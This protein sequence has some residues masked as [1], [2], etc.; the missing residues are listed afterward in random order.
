MEMMKQV[1]RAHTLHARVTSRQLDGSSS[2]PRAAWRRS[3]KPVL[4]AGSC[5]DYLERVICLAGFQKRADGGWV[6]RDPVLVERFLSP[7]NHPEHLDCLRTLYPFPSDD[8]RSSRAPS[9][10]EML[11]RAPHVE[12]STPKYE[13]K[14]L[15]DEHMIASAKEVALMGGGD[16]GHDEAMG[17][18]SHVAGWSEVTVS[19]DHPFVVSLRKLPAGL[20]VAEVE[21]SYESAGRILPS[22]PFIPIVH[23]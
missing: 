11:P 10:A 18:V 5:A 23:V 20:A 14:V 15:Y 7:A 19:A 1:K 13:V 17:V 4:F 9:R 6:A 3:V 21:F 16:E 2:A 22:Q 12:G 8:G